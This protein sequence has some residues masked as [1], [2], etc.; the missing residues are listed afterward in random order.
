MKLPSKIYFHVSQ[1]RDDG[2]L[3]REAFFHETGSLETLLSEIDDDTVG[4]ILLEDGVEQ[5]A[6]EDV[7]KA[8]FKAS[9]DEIDIE[10]GEAMVPDFIRNNAGDLVADFEGEAAVALLNEQ[11]HQREYSRAS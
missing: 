4:V 3:I 6:S 11:R 1:T 10:D 2:W 5:D 9:Q 8:W 7:A